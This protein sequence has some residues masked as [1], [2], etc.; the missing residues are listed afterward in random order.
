MADLFADKT[1]QKHVTNRFPVPVDVVADTAYL[2]SI[3]G[4]TL[5]LYYWNSNVLT[6]DAGQAAGTLV[7]GKLAFTGVLDSLGAMIGNNADTSLTFTTG[8]VLTTIKPFRADLAEAPDK[9]TLEQVAT[10]VTSGFT[11]GQYCVDHRNGIIYGIKATTGASDTVA[12]KVSTQTTGGGS[13]ITDKIDLIKVGGTTYS[14]GTGVMAASMPV[15]L[16]TDDTQFGA[17]GSASDVDGNIHA[18]LRYIGENAGGAIPYANFK[19]PDDFT[20]TYTSNVTITLSGTPFT[21][22]SAHV[23]YIKYIPS[24]GNGAEILVNGQK[25][26]TITIS[27][28]VITVDG[29]GTPF[30]S[31]DAYE[32][33]I[34]GQEKAFDASTNST[35]VSSLNNVWNQYTD[36]ETLVTAQDLTAAYADFGAEI[37]VRGY[38]TLGVF[39]V[40]DVNDSENVT[41]KALAKTTSGGTDE[42]E[43][44]SNGSYELWTTGAS[45][46]KTYYE[47]EVDA[48]PFIQLQAI[49]GTVG[50]TAGDLTIYI[51]KKY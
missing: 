10:A 26:V 45:D 34:N 3:T 41:L 23:A 42:F 35:M 14:L 47:F 30:A 20:A 12:Y 31:G 49:A 19:S 6:V 9:A 46:A 11:S 5:Q 27:S 48:I 7:I 4:E 18:Q 32:V 37:D 39:V 17:V 38:N 8:T 24:G 29:A 13:V 28:N 1:G 51:T 2:N 40:S 44:E 43:L 15:T 50:G 22:E 16:A 33:G 36:S 21:V 25:G